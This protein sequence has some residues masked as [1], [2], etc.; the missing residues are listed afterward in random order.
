[1]RTVMAAV[2]WG[3]LT[4]L[5][6]CA[7]VI[8]A[9]NQGWL[10]W[11][12]AAVFGAPVIG[13]ATGIVTVAAMMAPR[14]RLV[15]PAGKLSPTMIDADRITRSLLARA[16]A[17]AGEPTCWPSPAMHTWLRTW[18]TPRAGTDFRLMR[19]AVADLLAQQEVLAPALLERRDTDQ[20]DGD[21]DGGAR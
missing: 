14:T 16:Q 20:G 1:M 11:P 2:G 3:L 6:G 8:V 10:P 12:Y 9:V 7:G 18:R 15:L 21:E 4:A 13:G 5:G 17:R 19:Q